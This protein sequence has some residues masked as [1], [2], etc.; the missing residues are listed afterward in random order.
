MAGYTAASGR[1]DLDAVLIFLF[2]VCWQMPHFYAIGILRLGD[3]KAAKLPIWPVKYGVPATKRQIVIFI[4]LWLIPALALPA[5]G[6]ANWSFA[7]A[8]LLLVARWMWLARA[9]WSAA[10]DTTWA[11]TM[12]KFSLLVLLISCLWL[13]LL[14]A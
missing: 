10:D 6:Y 5:L 12:F 14:P 2:L 13:S 11:R 1:L 7:F 8:A 3:Y 4:G 9:G